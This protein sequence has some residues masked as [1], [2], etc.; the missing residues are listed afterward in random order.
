MSRGIQ[1]TGR[2]MAEYGMVRSSAPARLPAGGPAEPG[3][4]I[5]SLWLTDR[6]LGDHEARERLHPGV[7]RAVLHLVARHLDTEHVAAFHARAPGV[8]RPWVLNVLIRGGAD[9]ILRVRMNPHVEAHLALAADAYATTLEVEDRARD[10]TGD[11]RGQAIAKGVQ[12]LN[13]QVIGGGYDSFE[14]WMASLLTAEG[15]AWADNPARLKRPGQ[16]VG[17]LSRILLG[18]HG[19]KDD[20]APLLA[21]L[22]DHT[23]FAD[24]LEQAEQDTA[25]TR[26]ILPALAQATAS[27]RG[28]DHEHVILANS[29]MALQKL[30]ARMDGTLRDT[31]RAMVATRRQ[32]NRVRMT[33]VAAQVAGEALGRETLTRIATFRGQLDP[34]LADLCRATE[35]TVSEMAVEAANLAEELGPLGLR[36]DASAA[37]LAEFYRWVKR[38]RLM[39]SRIPDAANLSDL[40]EVLDRRLAAAEG[41]LL[42]SVAQVCRSLHVGYDVE[43]LVGHLHDIRGAGTHTIARRDLPGYGFLEWSGRDPAHARRHVGDP[44]G[45]SP[46]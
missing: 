44:G 10:R 40:T 31:A 27:V 11:A 32:V 13:A 36:C 12:W 2:A 5:D 39:V 24:L 34:G 17:P 19:L 4:Y 33:V 38:Y 37:A 8:T 25:V 45:P 16:A 46:R 21:A 30:A 22:T 14:A 29:G 1:V 35:Q 7:P 6:E 3:S 43:S 9:R 28:Q 41:G 20:C 26:T 42:E 23:A 15:V 18:V